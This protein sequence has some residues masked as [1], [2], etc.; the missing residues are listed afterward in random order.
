MALR[1]V[2]D[3]ITKTTKTEYV[4][5][6]G[7]ANPITPTSQPDVLKQFQDI[8][9]QTNKLLGGNYFNSSTGQQTQT[10]Q[11]PA[12]TPT[13]NSTN[14]SSSTTPN[15][16]TPTAPTTN[17]TQFKTS[18][19][20]LEKLKAELKAN[21]SLQQAQTAAEKRGLE[22]QI[23]NLTDLQQSNVLNNVKEITTPFRQALE[24]SQR[25]SLYVDENFE[26]NQKLT[27]E[28]DSLL[29]QGNE[30]IA[31]QKAQGGLASI[32]IPNLNKTISDVNAR[33]GV[34]QAVMS[35]R[36]NQISQA[37]NLI[38]R[39][40]NAINADRQDQLNYYNALYS[41]Y[42]SQKQT[43]QNKLITLSNEEKSYIQKQMSLIEDEITRTQANADNLKEVLTNPETA[44]DYA[45]AGVTLNDTPEQIADKLARYAPTKE[46]RAIISDMIQKY[47]DAGISFQDSLESAN[48]KIKR[49]PIYQNSIRALN[50]NSSFADGEAPLYNGLS[51]ATATAVRQ[52]VAGYKTEPTVTNFQVIQ[53]GY[54]FTQRISNK[55]VN[56]SDDQALIYALAKTLDPGSVVREGEYATAQKYAQSWV[57]AFG[58]SVTQA[59]NGTGFLSES[60]RQNIKKT[61]ETKYSSSKASYD[62]TYNQTIENI[63]SLTGRTDGARFIKDYAVGVKVDSAEKVKNFANTN[64]AYSSE[65]EKALENNPTWNYD[66][67]LSYL[68][69]I[70]PTPLLIQLQ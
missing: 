37:Y 30:L 24:E 33:A 28:L 36:N 9:S 44:I 21:I 64:P 2:Y 68:N 43:A 61:I 50:D 5:D 22:A 27:N 38:D 17:E 16:P 23:A 29:T 62:N 56:P 26:A 10:Y 49:S 15:I 69:I 20:E 51:S 55:T 41:F 18:Q 46:N 45:N 65:I 8:T 12:S 1:T 42:D 4:A 57:N 31:Q 19:A 48:A 53:D 63:N 60:A 32:A 58:K 13:V 40:V 34:I 67:V 7:S 35:A 47:P 66:D 25:K 54:N 3:P 14:I 11:P 70:L 59:L 6:S 39:S 52:Q